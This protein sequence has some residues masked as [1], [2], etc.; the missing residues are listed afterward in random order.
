MP[1]AAMVR[2]Q[3]GVSAATSTG[4]LLVSMGV[5]VMASGVVFALLSNLQ[6]SFA[7][8]GREIGLVAATT[9]V[10]N[11][12]MQ[13]SCA[14]FADRGHARTLLRAGILC[15]GAGMVGFALA[16]SFWGFIAARALSGAGEGL[17]GPAA[18]RV[19]MHAD[20]TRAAQG[21]SR[22][23]AA[24]VAGFVLGPPLG[25]F[26][27]GTSIRLPF[28]VLAVLL[29]VC[30]PGI[31]LVREPPAGDH[32]TGSTPRIRT[33][34]RRREIRAALLLAASLQTMF[35]AF[36]TLWARYF[37]DLGASERF[38]GISLALFPIPLVLL[39]STGGQ[40]ADRRGPLRAT[41]LALVLAGPVVASFGLVERAARSHR[42]GTGKRHPQRRV[43]AGWAAGH[44]P[45]LPAVAV[46][47][48]ARSVRCGRGA[49]RLR[50]GARGGP[51]VHEH[52]ATSHVCSCGGSFRGTGALGGVAWPPRPVRLQPERPGLTRRN[53]HR[54]WR[55]T[56]TDNAG[57][58]TPTA[59]VG[60]SEA[61]E[62]RNRS[63]GAGLVDDPY[64]TY[65]A[66][67]QQCPVH[68]GGVAI[69][70]PGTFGAAETTPGDYYTAYGYRT[71]VD[72]LKND[73][74]F[75]NSWYQG[76]LTRMIGPNMLGMDEPQ[77]KRMRML[78]QRAFSKREMR[79]WKTDIVEPIVNDQIDQFAAKGAADLYSDFAAFIPARVIVA[80]LGMPQKD[81]GQF[82]EW[83]I[84]MTSAMETQERR[85][86]ATRSMAEY[87]LPLCEQRRSD[88]Q[89][90]LISILVNAE[91]TDEDMEDGEEVE[92]HPLTDD[93]INGTLR[94]LLVG[95]TSTTFRAFGMML[96][97]LLTHPEQFEAVLRDRSL[98][99]AAI[100]ETL[101]LEQ[102]LVYWGRETSRDVT[103]SG[104][105]VPK[106]AFVLVNAGAG[107]HDPAEWPDPDQFNI[108]RAHPDR[109]LTFGFGKHHCLGVHLA[110]MELN[111]MLNT[112]LDRLPN[113]RLTETEGVNLTGLGFRMITKLPCAWD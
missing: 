100:E 55:M 87:V 88:P 60:R 4:L 103:L 101:R 57:M 83:A 81:L 22:L 16:S 97:L 42:V 93:E 99:D 105:E 13:I 30:L 96:F 48:R 47:G 71:C 5:V 41:A 90:D 49:R 73:A 26:L 106:G 111:V 92:R 37:D 27:V 2:H 61:D 53:T 108:H 75:K 51:A 14:R 12:A 79:W 62:I 82:F 9:F 33:L 102:P 85:D 65:H 40:Y 20:P 29:A 72:I 70:F 8:S 76:S 18:R 67:R 15:A 36:E 77:H 109:H 28:V 10:S 89:R 56:S 86:W 63:M 52:R 43:D 69:H 95:G 59:N 112:V 84:V 110:R 54:R 38:A 45:G 50:G 44:G 25:K 74:V 68:H 80:A 107:N 98:V 6:D 32:S 66:L 35:G 7:L 91:L 104:V 58:D 1:K 113:L 31:A 78:V 64:P 94:L 3:Q 19:I 17:F 11:V 24:A 39:A 46:G 21:L 34:L 23:G